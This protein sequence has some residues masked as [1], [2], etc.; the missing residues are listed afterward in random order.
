M[1]LSFFR[2]LLGKKT[3]ADIGYQV[4]SNLKFGIMVAIALFWADYVK[5]L[6]ED[7]SI[8]LFGEKSEALT[9][10]ILA[11]L[12]TILGLM[13]FEGYRTIRKYFERLTVE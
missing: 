13:V 5:I 8:Y 9:H 6:M 11:V 4:P 10:F 7:L 3:V 2:R 12:V 1:F